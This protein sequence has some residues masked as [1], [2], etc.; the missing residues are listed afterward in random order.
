METYYVVLYYGVEQV[1][2]SILCFY[3][4]LCS[5]NGYFQWIFFSSI[6]EINRLLSNGMSNIY[7]E[8]LIEKKRRTKNIDFLS[9]KSSLPS[10]LTQ[11]QFSTFLLQLRNQR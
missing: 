4:Y 3:L 9:L 8:V 2:L 11:S 1:F 5:F 10:Q 6:K 7:L